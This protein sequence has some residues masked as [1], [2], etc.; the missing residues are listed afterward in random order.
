MRACWDALEMLR[1]AGMADSCTARATGR[2]LEACPKVRALMFECR[3]GEDPNGRADVSARLEPA[4]MARAVVSLGES[5]LADWQVLAAA[6]PGRGWI[7]LDA[8]PDDAPPSVFGAWFQSPHSS[9]VRRLVGQLGDTSEVLPQ[10]GVRHIGVLHGRAT[11]EIRVVYAVAEPPQGPP[12]WLPCR[13]FIPS[14]GLR[15]RDQW[16]VGVSA[17]GGW[18]TRVGLERSLRDSTA[19]PAIPA[20]TKQRALLEA[21]CDPAAGRRFSHV[22]WDTPSGGCKV[23][24]EVRRLR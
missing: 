17:G 12:S 16:S 14:D 9:R 11:R 18:L 3:L 15:A 7:E 4:D 20:S 2:V 19:W 13:P 10:G 22:K 6:G 24:L 23:Y 1:Q 8:G 5:A 21:W